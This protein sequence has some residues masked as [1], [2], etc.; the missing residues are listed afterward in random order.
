V[1]VESEGGLARLVPGKHAFQVMPYD[2]THFEWA[3]RRIHTAEVI[4]GEVLYK[5]GGFCGPRL[6]RD[7]QLVILHSGDC[8]VTVDRRERRL[9]PGFVY[10]F[11][12]GH[13]E[14]FQFSSVRETHHSWCSIS[15]PFLPV[16]LKR[17]L[18]RAP[19][20]V[21][22]SDLFRSLWTAAFKV[23]PSRSR[24]T[25]SL[26]NQLGLCLAA[27]FLDLTSGPQTQ[28]HG[29]YAVRAFLGYVQ[30]HFGE[31]NCLS[32][33]HKAAGISR[34][35]LTYKLRKEFHTTPA[36]YLWKFRTERGTS[37]LV[38]TG[39]TIAEIASQ[40]GFKSPFHFSRSV[41]SHTGTSPREI[42]Q[43]TWSE[44]LRDR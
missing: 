40:C 41:K 22:S 43:R 11:L 35:A 7:F 12:P 36:R 27:E 1:W 5:L 14:Y 28:A 24:F 42:R 44:R 37:M 15:P 17:D 32:A 18:A 6:Q 26:I 30:D 16:D 34:N 19:F 9:A 4:F 39:H 21:P 13:K 8:C 10:L 25:T 31:E 2:G 38:E 23:R 29:D 3:N 20:A 33:A